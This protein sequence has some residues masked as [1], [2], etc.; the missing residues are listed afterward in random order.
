VS[1]GHRQI[2]MA[3]PYIGPEEALAVTRVLESGMLASGPEVAAF[4]TEF[5]R[6]VGDRSCTAV[7]SGTAAL[8]LGLLA[9][10]IGHGDDVIV[11][12]FTFAAT[13]NAVVL[14]G[15]DPVFVDIDPDTFCI[16]AEAIA[17]A[18]TPKTAGVMPVHLYGQ[19]ADMSAICDVGSRHSLAVFEDAAQAHLASRDGKAAGSVGVF[20]AFSFYPTKNM[21][22]AEGG[23][24]SSDDVLADK[25]RL[26]RN[27][28]MRERYSNEVVGFNA[29]LSDLHAAIG[30][31][32]L[33]RLADWTRKRQANA[34]FFDRNLDGVVT[35]TVANGA[36]HVYHQYTIRIVDADRDGFAR[37][38]RKRGID[39]GV[40]YPT[41]THA[42]QSFGKAVDLPQTSLACQQVLSLP[43]HPKLSEPDLDR[44]VTA[45]NDLAKA[46]A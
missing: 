21:T 38:L 5:S 42:L 15:A 40:Y 1:V 11:P 6:V 7:N 32:Q 10:G 41:P 26:L 14:A 30:R 4:E 9:A 17:A 37:E 8:H 33:G 23:M 12:S 34:D 44:I 29:R 22:S 3:S 36:T 20:G 43:V 2:P 13:A 27:Q 25:V 28:G 16:S 46:G 35:P 45:V 18:I 39:T 19:M 24:V 31:V